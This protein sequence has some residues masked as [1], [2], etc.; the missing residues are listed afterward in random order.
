ML[1]LSGESSLYRIDLPTLAMGVSVIKSD[2]CMTTH[3]PGT[4]AL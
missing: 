2:H 3:Y 1:L 4:L